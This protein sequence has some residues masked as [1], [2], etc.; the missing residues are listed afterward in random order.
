MIESYRPPLTHVAIR[1]RDEV[2]AL[3]A[4]ARHHHVVRLIVEKLGVDSVD[5]GEDDEGFLDESG[6]YLTRRQALVSAEWNDQ[7]R[8][9]TV[10]RA[11][12]LS[13]ENVW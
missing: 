5:V 13:S 10:V 8:P 9:G 11:G 1:F 2:Y 4:P 12:Q 3:P 6:R 7:L